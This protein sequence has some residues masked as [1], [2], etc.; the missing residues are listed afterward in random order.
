MSKPITFQCQTSGYILQFLVNNDTAIMDTIYCD[1]K[2]MNPLL[3]LLRQSYDGLVN[4]N[5]KIIQQRVLIEDYNNFL[6]EKTSWHV[7]NMDNTT[8]T[9]II[10]CDIQNFITNMAVGMGIN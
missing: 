3:H 10:E 2:Y 6:R 4:N 5:I 9:Y 7:I 1:Y 8:M